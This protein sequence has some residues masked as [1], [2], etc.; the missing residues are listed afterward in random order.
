MLRLRRLRSI[1]SGDHL[2][3]HR[4]LLLAIC[5]ALLALFYALN[6]TGEHGWSD[7]GAVYLRHAQNLL[8]HRNYADVL[9]T[10][11]PHSGSYQKVY[12]PLLPLALAPVVYFSGLNFRAFKCEMYFFYLLSLALIP[13]AFHNRL[14]PLGSLGAILLL[15]LNPNLLRIVDHINANVLALLL[16]LLFV[17]I[18]QR[19]DSSSLAH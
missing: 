5:I 12:P 16:N 13:A 10:A 3:M 17:I 7:D 9:F 4:Q 11:T 19:S 14:T 2:A 15:G 18:V 6:I 8:A 1:G